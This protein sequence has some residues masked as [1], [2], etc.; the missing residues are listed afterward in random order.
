M[1]ALHLRISNSP[2][3]KYSTSSSTDVNNNITPLHTQ[4]NVTARDSTGMIG[5]LISGAPLSAYT[6]DTDSDSMS[7][8]TSRLPHVSE[9]VMHSGV[10]WIM[11]FD[12]RMDQDKRWGQLRL[13]R[14][15]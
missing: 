8:T 1:S 10:A 4:N 12:L 7:T 11:L 3:T 6:G 2:L 13:Q 9:L 14:Q 15:L 5:H